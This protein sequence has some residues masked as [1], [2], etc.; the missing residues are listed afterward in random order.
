MDSF[1]QN[2][3]YS[4]RML[5][6]NPG[7]TAAAVLCL[8]LG[9]GATTAI[10]SVVNAVLLRPLRYAD[11]ARL[12]RVF[13]EF[14][15]FPNGGLRH[16][17]VSPPEYLDLRRDATSFDALEAWATQGVNLAGAAEPVRATASYVTGGMFQM[18]GV[19]PAAGRVLSLDDDRPNVP[20]TAVLSYNL[21]QRAYAGDRGVIGRDIRLNGNPCLVVGVMPPSFSFPP[22][23]LDPPELWLP[24]QIDPARPGGRGSH[25]L[26]VLARL[27][28]GV[29]LPQAEGE[30]RRY[31]KHTSEISNRR[32][33][34]F[35]PEFHPVVLAGF[36]DEVVRN[37]RPAMLVLL[38]AVAFVLLIACVN[39]ANLLLARSEARRRE[40]A[41]R[42]AIGAGFAR[43]LRQFLVEG[44]LLSL[45]GAVCGLLFAFGGLRLLVATNAGSI[46][47]VA[48]ID[49]DWQVLL[50]TL[51]VSLA[52]G[53]VFGLAPVLHIRP[54][55][56]YDI[57]KSAA[58]RATVS[59]A[60]NR[61][62]AALVTSEL[63]LALILLIGAGLMVKAFWRLQ[64]VAS[65]IDPRHLLTMR[66]SLPTTAYRDPA[67]LIGFWQALTTRVRSL[68][69]VVSASIASGLAPSRP[70]N[71]NDTQIEGFV[72]VPNGPIQNVDYWNFVGGQYFETVGAR[73]I[74]G[75]FIDDNDGPAAP[76]VVN[77]NQT[78][79]RTFWPNQSAIGHRVRTGPPTAPW[80]TVVGVIA[81][82]KNA[83][84]DRATGTELY[85]PYA[86]ASGVRTAYLLVRT[87]AGPMSAVGAVR[88]Q[89]QALDRALPIA[90]V[91]SMDDVMSAAR[92]RPRFLT[93]LLTLF[94]SLSL[95]LASIG[96]YGVISYSVA[97]RTNEIGI[98]MALGAQANDV[99]RLIGAAGLRLALA[100]AAIGAIGAFALT[101]FLSG[102]LFGVSSVDAAT[103][104]AMAA[105]LIA[106]T[107]LACYIPARRAS[108]VDPLVAL[109]YE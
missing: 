4:L 34:P 33:H 10:F 98:R 8:A 49:I 86:Q 96:I 6:A 1:T 108:K 70:I 74:E 56:L 61:F 58:G 75:R 11:S 109:R 102:L 92:S 76:P 20:L 68:P 13:T 26:S 71:A 38:G 24:F 39:V 104:A 14:P 84:L 12:L 95:A 107:L 46:P 94:S 43:L 59:G 88:A 62:R 72:P 81:D 23:E 93:L 37:V 63:A 28:P 41:I 106:V 51:A 80:Q 100:G 35:D 18:L 60:A 89:V 40:I 90:A 101:R 32:N 78:M 99:L 29:S 66:L 2:V 50:F 57:L 22:G 17:W 9:I 30:M 67:A 19:S 53:I 55:H 15:T 83:G 3:R 91:R 82:V 85:I 105:A 69:G 45:A 27:R 42:A 77:V 44:V 54:A 7:F 64:D 73:L 25:F 5:A 87:T 16:F 97:R 47:R 52:T 103:F 65:G 79:A 36:Q 48:E 21:W 31:V